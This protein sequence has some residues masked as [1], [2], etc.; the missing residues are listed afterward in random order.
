MSRD[1]SSCVIKDF[2]ICQAFL[3]ANH[4]TTQDFPVLP[5]SIMRFLL[6]CEDALVPSFKLRFKQSKKC[7][8]FVQNREKRRKINQKYEIG[9]K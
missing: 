8:K 9:K 5:T 7:L 2:I 3:L 6:P 4:L 1:E